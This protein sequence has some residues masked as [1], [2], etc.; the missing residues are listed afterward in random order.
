MMG[1]KTRLFHRLV[2]TFPAILLLTLAAEGGQAFLDGREAVSV[3]DYPRAVNLQKTAVIV[4]DKT[5]PEAWRLLGFSFRMLDSLSEAVSAY[6]QVLILNQDDYDAKLG[7]GAIF[8]L[9]GETGASIAVFA[10]IL[11]NDSTDVEAWLG[12]GKSY[13]WQNDLAEAEAAYRQALFHKSDYPRSI[14]GLAE[15]L[16][17]QDKSTE[18]RAVY[19]QLLDIDSTYSEAWTGLGNSWYWVDR[20]YRALEYYRKAQQLDENNQPLTGLITRIE[21]EVD[22]SH[23]PAYAYWVEDDAGLITEHE[24]LS[25]STGKRVNDNFDIGGKFSGYSSFRNSDW[26]YRRNLGLNAVIHTLPG[27]NIRPAVEMD[28]LS[29]NLDLLQ[30]LADF[31]GTGKWSWIRSKLIYENRLYELWSE[32]QAN[33]VWGEITLEK[34]DLF[35]ITAGTG[36]WYLSDEN[37]KTQESIELRINSFQ[38]SGISFLMSSKH[39]DFRD[40]VIGYWTPLHLRYH[41]VG[42]Q[43][44][45]NLNSF[46]HLTSNGEYAI[47]SDN[48]RFIRLSGSIQTVLLQNYRIST[49]VSYFK[50]DT[51]YRMLLWNLSFSAGGLL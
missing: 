37:E 22:W 29:G 31:R 17:W 51:N 18:A 40:T 27:F 21:D 19:G 33:G 39:L 46:I 10:G 16:A 30:L 26:S 35:S 14:L 49:G 38:E 6:E 23:E 4:D 50:T 44:R 9:Q 2:L 41:G 42:I 20:P 8:A 15:V 1:R 24:K 28:V 43:Y 36:K 11:A 45:G 32:T 3:S 13:S 7:L 48:N 5:N 34:R 12:I 47:N 25:F